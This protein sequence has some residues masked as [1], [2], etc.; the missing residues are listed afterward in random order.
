MAD[1]SSGNCAIAVCAYGRG[2]RGGVSI[3][4]RS[5]GGVSTRERS[6]GRGEYNGFLTGTHKISGGL[7]AGLLS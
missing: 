7:P 3:R 6:K 5:R 4:E 2:A 1:G